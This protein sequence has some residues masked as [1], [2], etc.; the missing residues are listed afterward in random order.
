MSQ[1][2]PSARGMGIGCEIHNYV[3]STDSDLQNSA[4]GFDQR[5]PLPSLG[6][7]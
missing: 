4:R 3:L 6:V 7:S 5:K 2:A 1:T